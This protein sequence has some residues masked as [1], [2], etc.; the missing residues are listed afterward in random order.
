MPGSTEVR[1]QENDQRMSNIEAEQRQ[2][3]ARVQL[4]E[5]QGTPRARPRRIGDG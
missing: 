1:F 3:E 4:L 2:I 5:R